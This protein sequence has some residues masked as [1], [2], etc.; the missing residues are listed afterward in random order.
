MKV[1]WLANILFPEAADLIGG[2][3]ELKGTGG[4]LVASAEEL[5]YECLDI[6][7]VSQTSTVHAITFLKGKN[8]Q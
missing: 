5:A 8:I 4:W 2:G 7:V 1:L 3:E 6:M